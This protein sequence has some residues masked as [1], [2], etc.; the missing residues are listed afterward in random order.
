MNGI[1]P[2]QPYIP[3]GGPPRVSPPRA[4]STV[5]LD[6]LYA[7]AWVQYQLLARSAIGHMFPTDVAELRAASRRNAEFMCGML[8]GPT[9]YQQQYG[10]PRMRARHLP[11]AID[12]AARQVWLRCYREAF[13]QSSHL[14]LSPED[15]AAL[16][17]WIEQFSAWMVNRKPADSDLPVPD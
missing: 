13:A 7:M 9:L 1:S 17:E 12:E 4:F 6:A 14:G 3:P 16:L 8:G 11:F 10:P 5:G 2:E 15:Q